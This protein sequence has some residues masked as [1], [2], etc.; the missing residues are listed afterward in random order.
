MDD[1]DGSSSFRRS[2]SV[3]HFRVVGGSSREGRASPST[4]FILSTE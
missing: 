1:G 3:L 2:S 4:M